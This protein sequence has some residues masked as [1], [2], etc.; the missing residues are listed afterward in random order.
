MELYEESLLCSSERGKITLGTGS[1][2]RQYVRKSGSFD[3]EVLHKLSELQC[4]FVA[5][6]AEYSAEYVIMEY[7]SGEPLSAK[8]LPADRLFE[9]FSEICSGISALHAAG[10]IHRD[11]KPSNIML[12]DSGKIK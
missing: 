3:T 6:V 10:I 11:I 9:I 12:T 2:G 1:D 4:P 7:I 8:N 5:S